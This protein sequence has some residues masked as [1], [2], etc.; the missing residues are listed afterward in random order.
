MLPLSKKE[1]LTA[2]AE[3]LYAELRKRFST[4]YDETQSIGF[5]IS[6]RTIGDF[7]S[8]TGNFGSN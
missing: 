4:E 3:P 2:V 5:Q 8:N 7:G 1:E 6:F